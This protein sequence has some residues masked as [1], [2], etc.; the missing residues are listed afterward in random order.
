[1]E[2]PKGWILTSLGSV[3]TINPRVD[4]S[5]ISDSTLVSFVPMASVEAGTGQIDS[6]VH[7]SLKEVKRGYTAFQEGDIL[8][9]KI[10]PCMEN[11]KAAVAHSL[12]SKIGFGSTEF[13]VL[14]P[15]EGIDPYLL[16]YYVAQESFRQLART[17]MTGTAGQLRVPASFLT[18][19]PYPLSSINEQHRIVAAIEQQF[20]R[21]DAGVAALQR[22]KA[23]LKR[24]RAAV[25]KAAVEG[26]L[27]ETWRAEHPTTE[28]ASLLLER[29]LNERCAKWEADLRAKGKD[30]TKVKYVEPA[31]PDEENLPELPEGWCW[32]TV[33][34]LSDENRAITYGVV[35]L[36]NPTIGGVPTLRSSN[37]RHL[38]F[39]LKGLKSIS[40]T[41][42][43]GYKRTFLQGGEILVTVR[44]T[45]GG[46]AVVP[47]NFAGYNI[48]REV[49][50]IA[51]VLPSLAP[52]ISLFI[53]SPPIQTWMM[54]ST[55]GIAYTGI[56]IETLKQ[57]IIPLPPYIEQEQIVAEVE[58]RLSIISELEATVK[59]NLKRAERLR[60]SILREAFAGRLVPQ[61]PTDEPASVLLE[62]I[63]NE[64]KNGH[65]ASI[66]AGNGRHALRVPEP[67]TL[68]VTE[69]E[70]AALWESIER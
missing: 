59:A 30:P 39:D 42:A 2:L 56:N 50:M 51:C 70:Q 34:Q 3:A 65:N 55:K 43:N 23:R 28:P 18:D 21:L 8:F 11:G 40:P 61:D 29:I 45:L 64:R 62:R 41:I 20:T 24:Y 32:V 22:A 48:S 31:K 37:V 38:R 44:G 67:V 25:L 33:E 68:D 17:Y 16:Y 5:S 60:Q 15:A 6:S 66:K 35:K 49:A 54:R 27:T 26:K 4:I 52:C 36:G 58:R 46:I 12:S 13:H 10:T 14:R 47:S 53:G 19:A 1:M 57:V 9:A 69:T 63:R 7:R